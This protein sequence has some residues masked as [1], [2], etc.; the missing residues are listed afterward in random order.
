[1]E[2]YLF[3]GLLPRLAYVCSAFLSC[4]FIVLVRIISL[5]CWP[6]SSLDTCA[7]QRSVI[8]CSMGLVAIDLLDVCLKC[9]LRGSVANMCSSHVSIHSLGSD[10]GV[11]LCCLFNN[12]VDTMSAWILSAVALCVC[13]S[14][15]DK[16]DVF[17]E[18][19]GKAQ[20]V[21]DTLDD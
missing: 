9:E 17:L 2:N 3:I 5:M 4:A 7:L 18:S 19:Q 16:W 12:S 15:C 10:F 14:G 13:A 20:C 1:M 11:L 6:L 8:V 21:M